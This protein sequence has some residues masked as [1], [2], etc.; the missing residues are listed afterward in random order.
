M[1][2]SGSETPATPDPVP[3]QPAAATPD[4]ALAGYWPSHWPAEDGGPRRAQAPGSATG[5]TAS[6]RF[7]PGLRAGRPLQATSRPVFMGCMAIVRDPGEVY[8]Q[9]N[10]LGAPSTGWV[11]R[12]HPESLEPLARSIDLPGG[13][14]WPGGVAAHADGSLYVTFGRWVHR[15]APDSLEVLAAHELP[16][17]RPYNSSVVLASGH[18]VTKDF[19]GG[20]GAAALPPELRG[21]EL[22]VLAPGTLEE[23]TRHELPEGSIARL[24][25]DAPDRIYVIGDTHAFGLRFDE[26]TAT[27]VE[28]W[29]VRYRTRDGQG[30]GWD[31]VI[32]DGSGWFLDD[33]EGTEAFG[34][35][36]AG[37]G[38]ATAPLQLLRVT[39]DGSTLDAVE[40]CG[41]PGGIIANPPC[42]D[43][44]RRIAV[45]FDSGNAQLVAWRYGEPGA[46]DAWTEL[47]RHD[48]HHAAHLLRWAGGELLSH[49]YDASRGVDQVVVRD[50]ETG[51]ELGRADTGSPV[52][53]VVFGAAGWADDA[54]VVSFGAVARVWSD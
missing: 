32:D 1:T 50:I 3:S 23:V 41:L 31:V 25:A 18:L 21:S 43:A 13:P 10:L 11:E 48:Q 46:A 38:V 44:G 17:E 16:R 20:V 51:D 34:G 37:K 45:G 24:S 36:F 42:V 2:G 9:G 4:P 39:L 7:A 52:Q 12:L 30:F 49:D 27:I 5:T 40:V 26:A 47:W 54:Y 28:D 8:L 33:G 22:V 53:S 15:L 14:F 19:G 6:I 29:R 35:H